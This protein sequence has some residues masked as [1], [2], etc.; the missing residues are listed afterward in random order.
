MEENI[1]RVRLDYQYYSGNDL[2]CDGE[3]EDELLE[4]AKKYQSETALNQVIFQRMKWPILYHFSHIRKNIVEWLPIKRE[5]TVLEIGA[6][7]GAITGALAKKAQMVTCVDLSKKRSMINAYRNQ[8]YDNIKIFV[9]N[10]K[11]IEGHLEKYNYI[12][13]IGVLEYAELYMEDENAYIHLL[14]SVKEHLKDN[15]KL[16]IAI[17]NRLGLK[18][19][20]GCK[21]DHVGEYFKGIEGYSTTKGVKTFSKKELELFLHACEF[22]AYRFFYP[23]PDYKFPT[24]IYSDDYLPK[25]GE[26]NNNIRNFDMERMLLFDESKVFDSL[27]ENGLFPLFSNSFLVVAE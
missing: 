20:A 7:C 9:G 15:G 5:E 11:D 8:Q 21:E 14:K 6:G 22:S 18:Y 13:L 23:Y 4:I 10:Y 12:T 17:E 1:G 26:L 3:I 2:Y 16:I 27:I 25:A 19:F 24:C